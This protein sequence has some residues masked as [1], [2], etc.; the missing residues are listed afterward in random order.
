MKCLKCDG[1][2]RVTT[3]YQNADRTTKRRRE[4]LSEKCQFRFTTRE[5]PESGEREEPQPGD[6]D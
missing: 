4:C 2:T 5:R 3:T 6:E 1:E